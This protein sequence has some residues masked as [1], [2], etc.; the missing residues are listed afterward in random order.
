ME[1][2]ESKRMFHLRN[3]KTVAKRSHAQARNIRYANSSAPA[4]VNDKYPP[5][6]TASR[7]V[8]VAAIETSENE[9]T[10]ETIWARLPASEI[11]GRFGQW[12]L[13]LFNFSKKM[14][15]RFLASRSI[16]V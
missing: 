10:P 6:R 9:T 11:R 2:R 13:V 16:F 15:L 1:A 12:L 8:G 4:C 3:K 7:R 14:R 5:A